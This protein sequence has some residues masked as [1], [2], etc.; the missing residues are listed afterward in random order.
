MKDMASETCFLPVSADDGIE[1]QRLM[2][3]SY[4]FVTEC[5][6]MA[7]KAIDLGYRVGVDKLIKQNIVSN[8]YFSFFL[9]K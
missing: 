1:E 7:H 9:P 2:A 4:N 5:F 8:H 6:Y 3:D